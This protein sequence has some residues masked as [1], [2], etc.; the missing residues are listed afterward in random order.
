MNRMLLLV[1]AITCC[2][3]NLYSQ[4]IFRATTAS[5]EER[6][7]PPCPT[8]DDEFGIGKKVAEWTRGLPK[9]KDVGLVYQKFAGLVLSESNFSVES[10]QMAL[11]AER[12][13]ILGTDK[14]AW[15]EFV[16]NL[17]AD[18]AERRAA[19]MDRTDLANYWSAIAKALGV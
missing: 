19:G 2:T 7:A 1:L 10:L 9:V 14:L 17:T 3:S 13:A 18:Y 12:E 4:E 15:T 5:Y 8:P 11:I 6:A 16:R